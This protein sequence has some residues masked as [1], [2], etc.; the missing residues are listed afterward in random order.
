M[1]TY[2]IKFISEKNLL[3]F[4][5]IHFTVFLIGGKIIFSQ[6]NSGALFVFWFIL[7]AS[8]ACISWNKLVAGKSE[9]I[10]DKDNLS[11]HW[12]KKFA[13]SSNDNISLRWSEIKEIIVLSETKYSTFKIKHTSGK[14]FTFIHND[15]FGND[16]FRKFTGAVLKEFTKKKSYS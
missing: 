3:V 16:D 1:E 14:I 12:L 7:I 10:M 2:R 8:I 11:M 6:T 15:M 9:W 13:F 5:L 4:I